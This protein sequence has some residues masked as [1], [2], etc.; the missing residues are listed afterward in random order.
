LLANLAVLGSGIDIIEIPRIKSAVQRWGDHFISRVFCDE[1]I[2]Y[3][4]HHRNPYPHYAG[5]FAAKEAVIK[6]LGDQAPLRWTDIKILN[7]PQGK[8]YCVLTGQ[9]PGITHKIFISIS[10][11]RHHAIANAIITP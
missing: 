3:A 5:R 1:E 10:H 2:E 4:R 7:D 9:P 8:P 6:A 11:T